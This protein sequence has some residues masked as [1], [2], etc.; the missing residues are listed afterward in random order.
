MSD[1]TV[2]WVY[3]PRGYR[4]LVNADTDSEG[5]LDLS[6]TKNMNYKVMELESGDEQVNLL[7]KEYTSTGEHI[8]VYGL[9][10]PINSWVAVD[11]ILKLANRLLP[12]INDFNRMQQDNRRVHEHTLTFLSHVVDFVN[13]GRFSL[14][15]LS[16]YHLMETHPKPARIDRLRKVAQLQPMYREVNDQRFRESDVARFL[17]HKDGIENLIYTL[18]VLFGE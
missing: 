11:Y 17:Q 10:T 8:T 15:P 16:A 5:R 3:Y 18:Y 6:A 13:R 14:S 1:S 9:S 12:S 2:A 7:Y 4:R